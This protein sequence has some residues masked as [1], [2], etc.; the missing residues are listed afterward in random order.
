MDPGKKVGAVVVA[1]EL[2]LRDMLEHEKATVSLLGR[3]DPKLLSFADAAPE[4]KV[5]WCCVET[6]HG[7]RGRRLCLGLLSFFFPFFFFFAM[8]SNKISNLFFYFSLL[9]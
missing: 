4:G 5:G 7:K 2:M 8:N 6:E 3:I 9:F 1:S